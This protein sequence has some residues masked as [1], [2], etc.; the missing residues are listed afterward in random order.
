MH[1]R[2]RCPK[3]SGACVAQKAIPPGKGCGRRLAWWF[4]VKRTIGRPKRIR[5]PDQRRKAYRRY[6]TRQVARLPSACK[7]M[8]K[9]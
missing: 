6:V 9:R 3:N 4:K 5:S 2:L 8:F 1:V 7:A